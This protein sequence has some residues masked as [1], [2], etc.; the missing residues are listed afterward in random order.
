[1]RLSEG[2]GRAIRFVEVSVNEKSFNTE[3]D[4]NIDWCGR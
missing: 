3:R 2:R 4:K 1:M